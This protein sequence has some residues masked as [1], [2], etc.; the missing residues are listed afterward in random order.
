MFETFIADFSV[1]NVKLVRKSMN[2][3]SKGTFTA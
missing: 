1:E 2:S 3:L